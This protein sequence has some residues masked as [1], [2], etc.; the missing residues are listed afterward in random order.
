MNKVYSF[1]DNQRF[2]MSSL[3]LTE[4]RANSF[5]TVFMA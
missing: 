3:S 5:E 1:D 4:G 2:Y